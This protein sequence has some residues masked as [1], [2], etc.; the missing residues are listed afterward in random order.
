MNLK[1]QL[2]RAFAITLLLAIGFVTVVYLVGS[3]RIAK[4]DEVLINAA[5]GMKTPGLTIVM[6]GFTVIGSG[7]VVALIAVLLCLFLY[8]VLGHRQE[9]VLFLAIIGGSAIL[10]VILKLLFHRE[11]PT[12][13]RMIEV[14][15][16][17]FPS[18]HS[19]ASFA[20]YGGLTY[21]LWRHISSTWG[22]A[23]LVLISVVFI[24]FIGVSRIYLGVHYPSDVVGGYL[25][26]GTWLG[27]SI[28]VFERRKN[29]QYTL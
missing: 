2:T 24:V 8:K 12:L 22:R 1:F 26:S 25:A 17:S 20:M 21:L 3:Q 4:F 16:Y 6:N 11:R 5:Q 7:Y 13:H 14:T 19:M 18:G 9:L 23:L 10:N 15:G 29:K 28:W 27:L